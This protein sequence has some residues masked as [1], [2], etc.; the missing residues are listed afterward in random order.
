MERENFIII[1]RDK[2]FFLVRPAKPQRLLRALRE[3][4]VEGEVKIEWCG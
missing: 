2:I 4:G 3:L 1:S